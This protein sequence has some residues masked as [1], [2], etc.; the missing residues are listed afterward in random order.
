MIATV[1]THE[2]AARQVDLG[3]P[4]ALVDPLNLDA[5]GGER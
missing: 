4:P 3:M 5:G 2:P 1:Q